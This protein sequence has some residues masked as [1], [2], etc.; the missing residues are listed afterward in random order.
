MQSV[1]QPKRWTFC[2]NFPEVPEAF[3][4]KLFLKALVWIKPFLKV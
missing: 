2:S 1:I 4:V 3:L